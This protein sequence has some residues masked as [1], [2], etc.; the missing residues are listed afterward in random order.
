[1]M[2][3]SVQASDYMATKLV[4]FRLTDDLFY[5]IGMLLE[6]KISGAPVVDD[7]GQLVGMLSEQDCLK[8]ILTLTYHE[9]EMGGKVAECMTTEVHTIGYDADIVH[10]AEKIINLHCRRLPV[11]KDGKLIGQISRRDVLKA[12][13]RFARDG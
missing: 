13:E 5:A 11:V 6:H 7:T 4:T 3:R 12:V 9:E 2:L 8:A 10:V 1:M